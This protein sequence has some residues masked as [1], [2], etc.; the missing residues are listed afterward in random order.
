MAGKKYRKRIARCALALSLGRSQ[1]LSL[2][3]SVAIALSLSLG[4]S[5]FI[6]RPLS[7][8]RSAALA[9]S[10]G[11]SR[12]ITRS[13][14]VA[15]FARFQ[16]Q[17]SKA[18]I[19]TQTTPSTSVPSHHDRDL[20]AIGVHRLHAR[21]RPRGE[22]F[23]VRPRRLHRRNFKAEHGVVGGEGG[24]A[25]TRLRKKQ[26]ENGDGFPE[27]KGGTHIFQWCI[28]LYSKISPGNSRGAQQ[29]ATQKH[30]LQ[31]GDMRVPSIHRGK[32]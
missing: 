16:K 32:K 14:S 2:Y 23:P 27:E 25:K 24:H 31:C 22:R 13:L 30:K 1:P 12:S 18:R 11:R 19:L 29:I 26:G 4:R 10:L 17:R 7:L 3:R 8:Y 20:P 9:L 15:F 28:I 21:K 5:L 6:A